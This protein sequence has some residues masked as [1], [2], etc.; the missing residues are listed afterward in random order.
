M[1]HFGLERCSVLAMWARGCEFKS[2]VA[3]Q[4]PG[5][6]VCAC[7][8]RIGRWRQVSLGHSLAVQPSLTSKTLSQ[9]IWKKATFPTFQWPNL[10]NRHH[11]LPTELLRA[12]AVCV[13]G[14]LPSSRLLPRP[15][16]YGI[17]PRR[18]YME[19]NSKTYNWQFCHLSKA[20]STAMMPLSDLL[21]FSQ[22]IASPPK[23]L[24]G[25]SGYHNSWIPRQ[26]KDLP[27]PYKYH[28]HSCSVSPRGWTEDKEWDCQKERFKAMFR[29]PEEPV[30]DREWR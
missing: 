16:A 29:K 28:S 27:P 22:S 3:T 20:F 18:A 7:D 10:G 13:P 6:A 12:L 26:K 15:P 24:L 5:M 17:P 25:Y 23:L 9:N 2:L 14:F 21:W 30:P 11:S 19:S 8:S 4:K 1:G